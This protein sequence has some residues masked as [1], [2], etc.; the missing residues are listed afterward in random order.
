MGIDPTDRDISDGRAI[1]LGRGQDPIPPRII[2]RVQRYQLPG[3]TSPDLYDPFTPPS[4]DYRDTKW[5]SAA[6]RGSRATRQQT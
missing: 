4:H 6:N 1:T 3:R 5:M 2:G